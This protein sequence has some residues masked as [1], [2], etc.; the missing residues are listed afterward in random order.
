MGDHPSKT[1][2]LLTPPKIP[3]NTVCWHR[4]ATRKCQDLESLL[5]LPSPSLSLSVLQMTGTQW[6]LRNLEDL[7]CSPQPRL[8]GSNLRARPELGKGWVRVFEEGHLIAPQNEP[9]AVQ[10]QGW[11]CLPSR[12][13]SCPKNDGLEHS[14]TA[15]AAHEGGGASC[16]PTPTSP[17]LSSHCLAEKR[18]T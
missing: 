9:W 16:F 5:S 1:I 15:S 2:S 10:G 13:P 11:S 6:S 14:A 17:S 8:L 12:A 3:L 18:S 4:A 7:G